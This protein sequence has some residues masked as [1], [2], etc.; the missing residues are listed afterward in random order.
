MNIDLLSF[1]GFLSAVGLF[2]I[3][4]MIA[5]ATKDKTPPSK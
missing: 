4:L 2:M 5:E 3:A 1:L